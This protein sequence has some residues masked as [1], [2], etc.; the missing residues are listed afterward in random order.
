MIPKLKEFTKITRFLVTLLRRL[1]KSKFNLLSYL[2]GQFS[3]FRVSCNFNWCGYTMYW[4]AADNLKSRYHWQGAQ[5]YY[6]RP[7]TEKLLLTPE[8]VTV[9]YVILTDKLC[10]H[11]AY[12][13]LFPSCFWE[14]RKNSALMVNTTHKKVSTVMLISWKLGIYRDKYWV[15]VP[16]FN[17]CSILHWSQ[18]QRKHDKWETQLKWSL[19]F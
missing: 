13:N 5:F 7:L 12:M 4:E 17:R 15:Y 14:N 8:L 10:K 18:L 1:N 11:N 6:G 19:L 16:R 2:T 9:Q 3:K